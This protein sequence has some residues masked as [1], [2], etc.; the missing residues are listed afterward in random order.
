[1][2][3]EN[4]DPD[5][6]E[7]APEDIRGPVQAEIDPAEADEGRERERRDAGPPAVP[8]EDEACEGERAG[9][10]TARESGIA[11]RASALDEQA[12][13][14]QDLARSRPPDRVLDR[15]RD[16]HGDPEK[17]DEVERGLPPGAEPERDHEEPE[18]VFYA[19]R[20]DEKHREIHELV[21]ASEVDRAKEGL[22]E[23]TRRLEEEGMHAPASGRA[24]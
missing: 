4:R 14:G 7:G 16:E 5:S 18:D 2:L 23:A 22:V 20:G 15:E 3:D 21:Q 12:D 9:R 17:D 8:Q 1:M 13:V 11:V 6:E 19:E 10:M 24:R